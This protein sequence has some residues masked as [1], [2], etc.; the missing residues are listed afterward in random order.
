M[1]SW[2]V[3]LKNS[4][5]HAILFSVAYDYLLVHIRVSIDAMEKDGIGF[6]YS[7]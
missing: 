2:H 4:F 5:S 1:G 3:Q 6:I 7:V